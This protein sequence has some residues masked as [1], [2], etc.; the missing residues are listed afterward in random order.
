[1]IN[2]IIVEGSL[3]TTLHDFKFTTEGM[4]LKIEGTHY[5]AGNKEL[6]TNYVEEMTTVTEQVWNEELQQEETIEKQIPTGEKIPLEGAMIDIQAG[7]EYEIWLCEDGIVVLTKEIGNNES[8][9][10]E[11][12]SNMIDKLAW[13][14]VPQGVTTLDDVEINVIEI[15]EG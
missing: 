13:F 6:F 12:P 14:S 5:T 9:F 7:Y 10:D 2:S 4:V 11:V 1:M 8:Q 15:R 3:N